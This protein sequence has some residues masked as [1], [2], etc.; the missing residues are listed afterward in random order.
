MSGLINNDNNS[1]SFGNIL[2]FDF[3]CKNLT[4]YKKQIWTE[5]VIFFII[6]T[7]YKFK[8]SNTLHLLFYPIIKNK[9]KIKL[10]FFVNFFNGYLMF[11]SALYFSFMHICQC[12]CPVVSVHCR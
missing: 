10:D 6:L 5:I 11:Y 7:K 8:C 3:F 4:I 9:I 12:I 1:C 2:G